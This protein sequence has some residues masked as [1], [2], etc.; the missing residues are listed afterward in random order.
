[1]SFSIN[2]GAFLGKKKK[3]SENK[4]NK[5]KNIFHSLITIFKD[6]RELLISFGCSD[7]VSI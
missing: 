3:Y 2:E 1:M 6:R 4:T 7:T 5:K